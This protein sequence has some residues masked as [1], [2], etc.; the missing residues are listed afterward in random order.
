MTWIGGRTLEYGGGTNF[1]T[2][3]D[4]ATAP[5]LPRTARR[6]LG[7]KRAINRKNTHTWI[8]ISRH[9]PVVQV[10]LDMDIGYSEDLRD[11]RAGNIRRQPAKSK[12]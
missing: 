9:K 1:E 7:S 4:I 2:Q 12:W 10:E 6:Q 8:W 3:P 5:E 11:D